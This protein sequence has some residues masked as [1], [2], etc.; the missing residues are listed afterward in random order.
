F[1]P[2]NVQHETKENIFEAFSDNAS[3][4]KAEKSVH[5]N[6]TN[7]NDSFVKAPTSNTDVFSI[8]SDL[9][10]TNNSTTNDVKLD[11]FENI[12]ESS[13]SLD[14]GSQTM[15]LN[16]DS[17]FTQKESKDSADDF[18][19]SFGNS[20]SVFLSNSNIEDIVNKN[21]IKVEAIVDGLV[22]DYG[23]EKEKVKGYFNDYSSF[24]SEEFLKLDRH[25]EHEDNEL[26]NAEIVKL[27]GIS[28]ILK[29]EDVV[30]KLTELKL[31]SSFDKKKKIISDIKTNINDLANKL[32]G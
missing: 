12:N 1:E 27:I 11:K 15:N 13:F 3:V 18:T 30:K 17:D 26:L 29:L 25:L 9:N 20:D 10:L 22:Q 14:F 8:N 5:S 6:S 19:I 7:N 24:A 16:T 4:E 2:T 31:A 21:E 32:K 28:N 23:F